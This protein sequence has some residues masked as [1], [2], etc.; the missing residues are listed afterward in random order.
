[1]ANLAEGFHGPPQMALHALTTH[2]SGWP[3]P[4][5]LSYYMYMVNPALPAAIKSRVHADL[6]LA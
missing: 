3:W 1:M 5:W 6:H 4:G 2:R